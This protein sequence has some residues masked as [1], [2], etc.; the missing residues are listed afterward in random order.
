MGIV[1]EFN[2]DLAI[3]DISEFKNGNKREEECIFDG[4]A[5]LL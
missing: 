1:I 3:R 4:F 2:P 5:K